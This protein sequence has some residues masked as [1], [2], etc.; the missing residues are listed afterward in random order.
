MSKMN[1][2]AF[3]KYVSSYGYDYAKKASVFNGSV[4]GYVEYDKLDTTRQKRIVSVLIG[5]TEPRYSIS[6]VTTL[7]DEYSKFK[8]ETLS[9]GFKLYKTEEIGNNENIKSALIKFSY[10]KDKQIIQIHNSLN[11]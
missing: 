8:N 4:Y 5:S 10:R 6:Y 1:L 2:E 9:L 11:S 7:K 3:D